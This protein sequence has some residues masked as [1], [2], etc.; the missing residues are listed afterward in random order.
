MKYTD[1][2]LLSILRKTH[3]IRLQPLEDKE[4]EESFD[5]DDYEEDDYEEDEEDAWSR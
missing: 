3:Q 2:D 5:E 4:K 1:E